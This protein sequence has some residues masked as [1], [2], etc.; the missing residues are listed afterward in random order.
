MKSVRLNGENRRKILANI[1]EFIKEQ[2]EKSSL[3]R[4]FKMMEYN[5]NSVLLK[6]RF[7]LIP[8]QHAEI[9]EKYTNSLIPISYVRWEKNKDQ[10][11]LMEPYSH[12]AGDIMV[13]GIKITSKLRPV[14]FADTVADFTPKTIEMFANTAYYYACE[15]EVLLQKYRKILEQATTTKKLTSLNPIW[16][17]FVVGVVEEEPEAI[18]IPAEIL[19]FEKSIS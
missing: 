6:H 3:G 5:I 19:A 10:Y 16:N 11:H 13:R 9:I 15:M 8:P 1:K 14:L 18:E 12:K 7:K 17:T 4:E 2:Q